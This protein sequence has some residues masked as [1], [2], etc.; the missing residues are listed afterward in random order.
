M[1]EDVASIDDETTCKFRFIFWVQIVEA[2]ST[3][4]FNLTAW[5]FL[6]A[7][8]EMW[9]LDT[10]EVE[11]VH[12]VLKRIYKCAPYCGWCLMSARLTLR[13]FLQGLNKDEIA[14][15]ID[16]CIVDHADA[17]AHLA[18]GTAS[19]LNFPLTVIW[20]FHY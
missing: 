8:F 11:G 13:K 1:T 10:Q 7:L 5:M 3:G 6:H 14:S 16:D 19:N 12:N 15:F 20:C 2:A 18:K 9:R 4:M 17:V